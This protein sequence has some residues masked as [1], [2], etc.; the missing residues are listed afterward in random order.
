MTVP[1]RIRA[2]LRRP[3]AVTVAVLAVTAVA[4]ALRLYDLGARA[5]HHDESLHATFAW[6]FVDGRGYSHD[7]LMHGPLQFHLL[8]ALFKF[9]GDGDV[10]ARL[11]A[12]VAGSALVAAPL[13]LR[14]WLGGP[15]TVIA[16]LMLAFS[17]VLLYF[18]RFAR[19]DLLIALWT[20]LLVAA[21]WRYRQHGGMRW[22]VLLATVLA[23]SFATKETIYLTVAMLLLYLDVTLAVEL[24]ARRAASGRR[25]ALETAALLPL[26]WLIA[27]AWRPLASRL[28]LGERPREADLLVVLGTLT[29]PF[30]AAA[31]AF[32]VEALTGTLDGDAEFRVGLVTVL[33]LLAGGAAVGLSWDWRRWAALA[34]LFFAITMPL[35]T[36]GFTNLEGAGSGLWGSLDY[37]LAQQDVR[38]GTQPGFYYVM[39]LPLYEFLALLPALLGGAWLL[40]RGDRLARL[41]GWWFVG[42][43]MALSLAGEKMP[44]L[45][46]HLAL[47]LALLAGRALGLALPAAMRRLRRHGASLASWAGAGAAV[48]AGALL[49]A[50]SLRTAFEVAYAHPDTPLEPLIYTQTSPEVP[51]LLREIEAFADAG[52]GRDQ[53]RITVDTTRSFSWPW[54]WYLRGFPLAEFAGPQ[55]IADRTAD[56][57]IVIAAD[58]TLR[59][60]PALSARFA[61]VRPYRHRW[62]FPEDGYKGT[63][64]GSLLR[65]LRDGSLVADWIEFYAGRVDEAAVGS[66][67]GAVLFPP[68]PAAQSPAGGAAP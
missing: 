6:Y 63:T 18:S 30:L 42:T 50:L 49:L 7:P 19:N 64:L 44:W 55:I 43:L 36:T 48:A 40:W 56:E 16:A 67:D 47:P 4:L 61:D 46:V 28:R 57:G 5:M 11:P 9:F 13:L 54:A 45:N 3:D 8:A 24:A 21:V 12:A 34:A 31:A 26:A 22:L 68:R 33:L 53:L 51:A 38:R 59:A 2:R 23:L 17:P 32:P 41:L 35:Y 65:G 1:R 62:W 29:L 52:A 20:L 37:W 25:R 10:T 15:G 14:R 39:M 27:A 60:Y 58:S 66:I